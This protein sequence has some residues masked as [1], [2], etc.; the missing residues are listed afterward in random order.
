MKRPL[1]NQ[2]DS[3][4]VETLLFGSNGLNDEENAWIKESTIEYIVT[5]ARFITLL[6]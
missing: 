1:L 3:V 4:I 5:T 2:N 6:L